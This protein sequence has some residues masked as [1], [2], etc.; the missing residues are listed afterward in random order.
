M[1]KIKNCQ[2]NDTL[3]LYAQHVFGRNINIC[4]TL[5]SNK[6]VSRSHA[7]IIWTNGEWLLHDHSRNGT[8][9]NDQFIRKNSVGLKVGFKI[10]FGNI[11]NDEWEIIDLNPPTSYIQSK[12]VKE[13]LIVLDGCKAM[14]NEEQPD[15]LFYKTPDATW[16][17]ETKD[18]LIDLKEEKKFVYNNEE[19]IFIENEALQETIDYGQAYEKSYFRFDLSSDEEDIVLSLNIQNQE[20]KLGKKSY[21]YILLALARKKLEDLKNKIQNDKQGWVSIEELEKDVSKELCHEVDSYYLN[22]QI[23]RIRK[24]LMDL[25]PFGYIFSNVIERKKGEI[26]FAFPNLKIFKHHNCIAEV[27]S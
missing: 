14:P 13:K 19:W 27:M 2:T 7:S 21:N 24:Q 12:T 23:Y 17:V 18:K 26:R 6:D 25:R 5:I 11:D 20:Y 15:I 9:L 4:N 22:L 8:L 16:V 3:L 1:A 10:R